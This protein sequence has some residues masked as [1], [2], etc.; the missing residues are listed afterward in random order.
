[1]TIQDKLSKKGFQLSVTINGGIRTG[2]YAT[3][4]TYG[5]KTRIYKTQ[6]ELLNA[7]K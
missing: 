2:Y 4:R 7:I 6:T 1:M 5:T 3:N